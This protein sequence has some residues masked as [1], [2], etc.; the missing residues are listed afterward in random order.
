M[1]V[2][3]P[4]PGL[5]HRRARSSAV[6][7]VVAGRSALATG[8]R[9]QYR[10]EFDTKGIRRG[11][12]EPKGRLYHK[13][14]QP[15]TYFHNA[16]GINSAMRNMNEQTFRRIFNSGLKEESIVTKEDIM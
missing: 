14:L 7:A 10:D 2:A 8:P 16:D 13:T 4:A 6:G 11:R 15:N 3:Q 5:A 9:T 1:Q 12:E